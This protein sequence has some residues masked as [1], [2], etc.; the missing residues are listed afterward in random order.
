MALNAKPILLF[1]NRFDDGTPTATSEAT[2]F[3]IENA[4]DLREY[5]FWKATDNATQY[6]T[7]DCASAKSADA[8][9]IMGHNLN[10]VGATVSVEYSTTGA[11][12]GEEVEALAGFEPTDDTALLKVFT[13]AEKRYW[14]V[15]IAGSSAAPYIGVLILGERLTMEKYISGG[16]FDPQPERPVSETVINDAGHHLGTVL[17]RTEIVINASWRNLIPAWVDSTFRPA[18]D[19]YLSQLKPFFWAW[20][21]T[22]HADEVHFVRLARNFRLSM[23]YT[24]TR[25]SLTLT[26][27]ALKES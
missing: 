24:P 7:I 25:R 15:K 4:F 26:F 1:D 16:S 2:G 11:W 22:N 9:G 12:G 20:D 27:Q 21:I 8:L 23:P 18:W 6:L 10:T 19:D 13:T 5:M 17:D 3:P 14:R